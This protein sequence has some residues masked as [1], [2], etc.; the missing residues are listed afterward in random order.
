MP[1]ALATSSTASDAV[2]FSRSRI[3]F[4][5]TT[6]SEPSEA[7]LGDEL[8]RE[9]RLPVGEAAAHRRAD[10]RRHL[11]VERVHVERDVD[12]AGA[13]DVRERLP[14]R[15][16]D[17]DPVDVA[18][19]VRLDPE[20]ADP[21]ALLRVDRAEADERHARRLDGG[22]RPGIALRSGRPRSRALLRAASRG[23]CR[24][25]TSRVCSCR[26][27]ASIQSTPPT[28]WARAR[29][30]SV[31]IATE[32]SPPSTSGSAPCSSARPTSRAT[33]AARGLD[34][35]QVARRRVRLLGRL[36]HGGLD[37]A[38]VEHLVAEA[39]EAVVQ[40]GVADRRRAHVDAAAA[41]AEVER[42]ADDRDLLARL[43]GQNPTQGSG[44][45]PLE[46][47]PAPSARRARPLTRA[48]RPEAGRS[49]RAASSRCPRARRCGSAIR[50][51]LAC[52]TAPANA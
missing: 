42:G 8:E 10:A 48:G 38:P 7:G 21:L 50:T 24:S 20:L 23:R 43:H 19:R 27:W 34:L 6:S 22:Q 41:R 46:A 49:D 9:V 16:L 13:G 37:V 35:R 15:P 30:P 17:P 14:D 33:R 44:C 11:G 5:S 2:A 3:G 45:R 4:T 25:A 1:S 51:A 32:W 18:H 12:E 52:R 36:E 39:L 47:A 28:P 31:P 29:P 40:A 26:E